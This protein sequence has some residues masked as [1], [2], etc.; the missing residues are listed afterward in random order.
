MKH[1]I[2]PE[3]IPLILDVMHRSTQ[4]RGRLKTEKGFCAVGCMLEAYRSTDSS[5]KWGSDGSYA[6]LIAFGRMVFSY[7]Q[8][9]K[10]LNWLTTDGRQPKIDLEDGSDRNYLFYDLNDNKRWSFVDFI[11]LLN[12][13]HDKLPRVR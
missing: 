11:N 10:I 8:E 2:R 5:A 9:E 4:E 7:I 6:C 12:G 13:E 1:N 3:V